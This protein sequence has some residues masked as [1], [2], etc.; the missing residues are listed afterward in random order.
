MEA[1]RLYLFSETFD[2]NWSFFHHFYAEIFRL[3]TKFVVTYFKTDK[4]INLFAAFKRNYVNVLE[5][6]KYSKEVLG[7]FQH[8]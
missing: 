6:S 4:K 2:K 8:I 1:G 3:L 7:S 5:L